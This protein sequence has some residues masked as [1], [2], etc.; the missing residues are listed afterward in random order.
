MRPHIGRHAII[1]EGGQPRLL[2]CLGC[3]LV[4]RGETRGDQ[5]VVEHAGEGVLGE[6]DFVEGAGT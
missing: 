6:D 2:K 5:A 3:E 1:E 4:E